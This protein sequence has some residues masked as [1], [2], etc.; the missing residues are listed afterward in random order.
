MPVRQRKHV[1]LRTCIICKQKRQKRDLIRIVRTPEGGIEL[2]S[3]GKLSGRGAYCCPNRTCWEAALEPGRLGKVLKSRL[4]ADDLARLY[5][6]V[7]IA[8]R[9]LQKRETEA[10]RDASNRAPGGGR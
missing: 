3:R 6:S 4:S 10:G 1:P 9:Q 5:D 2:D 7:S 8:A